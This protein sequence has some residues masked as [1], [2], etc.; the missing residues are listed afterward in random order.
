MLCSC[1]YFIKGKIG[2]ISPALFVCRFSADDPTVIGRR[3]I[4]NRIYIYWVDAFTALI[5]FRNLIS[6]PLPGKGGFFVRIG[7][8]VWQ[9]HLQ[10][11]NGCSQQGAVRELPG[12][13]CGISAGFLPSHVGGNFPTRLQGQP[14]YG[15]FQQPK[16]DER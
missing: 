1:V 2:Q 12:N 11:T 3:D 4:Y 6:T 10:P 15:G 5:L 14:V 13:R 8:G 16:A 7:N 9:L